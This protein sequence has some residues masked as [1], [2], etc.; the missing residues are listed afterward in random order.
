[1]ENHKIFIKEVCLLEDFE[2]SSYHK[3]GPILAQKSVPE[4]LIFNDISSLQHFCINIPIIQLILEFLFEKS[5][6][7]NEDRYQDI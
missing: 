6:V 1:M 4:N 5:V 2:P 3:L 7:Y